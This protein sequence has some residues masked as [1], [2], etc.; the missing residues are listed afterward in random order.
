MGTG[1]VDRQ[2]G[3]IKRPSR[4]LRCKKS[5]SGVA[6]TR[7]PQ[8]PISRYR[9]K[10]GRGPYASPCPAALLIFAGGMRGPQQYRTLPVKSRRFLLPATLSHQ[11]S[12]HRPLMGAFLKCG[13]PVVFCC[14]ACLSPMTG[15]QRE[16]MGGIL[17][18]KAITQ[19]HKWPFAR[20]IC[21]ADA[22]L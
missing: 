10:R 13:S 3:S 8:A 20:V 19:A 9:P 15:M 16:R 17:R 4:M 21:H 12:I 7:L 18:A 6:L 22:I 2:N 5:W 11:I 1:Y 14:S